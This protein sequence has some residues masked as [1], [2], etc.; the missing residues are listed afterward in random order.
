[1]HQKTSYTCWTMMTAMPIVT[2]VA[3]PTTTVVVA[4]TMMRAMATKV[5]VKMI[6]VTPLLNLSWLL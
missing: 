6:G 5:I 4:K 1:M 3:M 2:I